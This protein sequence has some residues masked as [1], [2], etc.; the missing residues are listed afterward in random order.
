MI[1]TIAREGSQEYVTLRVD[2]YNNEG[3]HPYERAGK[4]SGLE[5][6]NRRSRY[7]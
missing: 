4:G 3:A 5:N 2:F 6:P 1:V 7:G